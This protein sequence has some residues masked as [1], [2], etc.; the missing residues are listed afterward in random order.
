MH[1]Q[2]PTTRVAVRS[3]F[4]D[5]KHFPVWVADLSNEHLDRVL[6]EKSWF[7]TAPDQS[8]PRIFPETNVQLFAPPHAD[9]LGDR[10][11]VIIDEDVHF[12]GH[13]KDN[14]WESANRKVWPNLLNMLSFSTQEER[15]DDLAIESFRIS[16]PVI[17]LIR[18]RNHHLAGEFEEFRQV[19][20]PALRCVSD[21]DVCEVLESIPGTIQGLPRRDL[22]HL[23]KSPSI[24]RARARQIVVRLEDSPT[25][26]Q[27][28]PSL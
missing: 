7:A 18:A 8:D 25:P 14:G 19:I 12:P 22:V 16:R 11:W 13:W 28:G 3:F 23:L 17:D 4:N 21:E 2:T 1:S 20:R 10:G 9:I 5:R 26:R 24:E 27:Q 15:P 6:R